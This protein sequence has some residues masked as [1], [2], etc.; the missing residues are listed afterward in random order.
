MGK[1][2][3][4]FSSLSFW[5]KYPRHPTDDAFGLLTRRF[6]LYRNNRVGPN[7]RIHRFGGRY[8]WNAFHQTR[9]SGAG[10]RLSV[11]CFRYQQGICQS[12][13]QRTKWLRIEILPPKRISC[14]RTKQWGS[15]G[16]PVPHFT[17]GATDITEPLSTGHNIPITT[18]SQLLLLAI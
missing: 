5:K 12:W 8:D 11:Y 10:H 6:T 15:Y 2:C 9:I 14:N 1:C 7:S 18:V 4:E 3:K 16:K 17:H 13:C